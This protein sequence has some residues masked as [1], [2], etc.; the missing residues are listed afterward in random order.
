MLNLDF[1]EK[2]LEIVSPPHFVYDFSRKIFLMS[3]SKLPK[4]R[5]LISLLLKILGSLCVN[6]GLTNISRYCKGETPLF[7]ICSCYCC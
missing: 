4:I 2:D 1:L 6:F 5:C 3:Y 7:F